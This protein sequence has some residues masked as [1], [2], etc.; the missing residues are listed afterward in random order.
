M[1]KRAT[2]TTLLEPYL[3]YLILVGIGLGTVLLGQGTR[4]ALLWVVLTALCLFYRAHHEVALDYT[5]RAIG[6]GALLGAVIAIPLMAFLF[7]PLR[8][9]TERLYG[10]REL[11]LIFYQACFVAAPLEEYFFRGIVQSSKGSSVSIGLYALTALLYYL[12]HVPILAAFIVFVAMGLLGVV[13]S[14]VREHYGLAAAIA[15]HVAVVFILLVA[16]A[17]LVNLRT[18][19]G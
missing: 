10:T 14:Y 17:L 19:L 16:P 2:P 9:F 12:P 4:L 5:L 1:S 7:E 15:C 6:R 18:M 13:Y 11:T 3:L 8:L